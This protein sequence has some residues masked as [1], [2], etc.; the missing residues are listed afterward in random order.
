M[1]FHRAQKLLIKICDCIFSKLLEKE[2]EKL[3]LQVSQLIPLT[4]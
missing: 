1:A 2:G 4:T 3:I